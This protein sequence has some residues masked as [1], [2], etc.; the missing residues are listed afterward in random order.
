MN[1]TSFGTANQSS[2][3]WLKSAGPLNA[4]QPPIS[5]TWGENLCT[6]TNAHLTPAW[7]MF[8]ISYESPFI[9]DISIY[10]RKSCTYTLGHTSL[11]IIFR[12]C[13]CRYIIFFKI[14]YKLYF[15]QL[16]VK[17][18]LFFH[19][20]YLAVSLFCFFLGACTHFVSLINKQGKFF[21]WM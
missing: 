1:L 17:T 7:W 18:E 15:F 9:T 2:L 5:N 6:H 21:L 11:F 8:D 19:V 10:Y 4:I 3:Y 12:W 20:R 16:A 14:W 13:G